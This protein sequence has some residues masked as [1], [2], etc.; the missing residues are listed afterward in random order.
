MTDEKLINLI[1][2]VFV[3]IVI[4]GLASNLSNKTLAIPT[5]VICG[6]CLY[7]LH[8]YM[9]LKKKSSKLTC[10][11]LECAITDK[12]KDIDL[13]DAHL[14]TKHIDDANENTEDHHPTNHTLDEINSII[15]RTLY[16]KDLGLSS[17][18]TKSLEDSHESILK[19]LPNLIEM[20]KDENQIQEYHMRDSDYSYVDVPRKKY[21]KEIL[22]KQHDNEFD[23]DM[24][25]GFADLKKLHSIMGSGA[26]TRMANRMKY[27]GMQS[28]LSADI[29]AAYHKPQMQVYL[30]E[31][32]RDTYENRHWWENDAL[33]ENF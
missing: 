11:K 18:A 3:C 16:E 2:L 25:G 21:D 20:S 29:R 28:K 5:I 24:Y 17:T 1:F 4:S 13:H 31:E 12:I 26:D 19:D 8:D 7:L 22:T 27:L 9:K 33:D 32:L 15:E 30:E 6:F 23:I 10:K 14:E